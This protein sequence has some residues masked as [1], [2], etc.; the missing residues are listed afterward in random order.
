MLVIWSVHPQTSAIL[1]HKHHV[2]NACLVLAKL[3]I[4]M[5][6]LQVLQTEN[7]FTYSCLT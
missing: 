4:E 2:F 5:S 6:F 7:T 1:C 3:Q